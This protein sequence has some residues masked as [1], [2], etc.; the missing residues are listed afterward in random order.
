MAKIAAS[1]ATDATPSART[2]ARPQKKRKKSQIPYAAIALVMIVI[3]G[4]LFA[5]KSDNL[6]ISWIFGIAFGFVLQKTRF[7]FTASLRDP[8]L[9][10][11][12]SISKA[13]IIAFAIA[14]AGFA[15]IQYSASLA[16]PANI[17][18][19]VHPAGIHIMIGATLFGIG[20]VIAGGCASGTL[21]R[22]GE[23]FTMQ[24]ITIIGFVAGSVW[25]IRDYTFWDSNFFQKSPTIWL[26][27]YLGWGGA[28]FLQLLVLGLLYWAADSFSK[29]KLGS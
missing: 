8:V 13:V 14:T 5:R 19:N 26:P 2:G 3:A 12:T 4:I 6:S 18:G 29:R 7:C 28:V 27:D 22:M 25:G 15:A 11:S 9:T 1:T 24:W 21:M 16:D 20:M 10:G 23:G 17:P